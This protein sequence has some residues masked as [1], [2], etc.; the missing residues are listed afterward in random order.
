MK[1]IRVGVVG[2]GHRGR[3][4]LNLSAKGFGDIVEPAAACDIRPHNWYEKQW[5][6]DAPMAE[7]FPNAQFFEDYDTMLE[8]A[9]LDVVIVETGADIHAEFCCKALAR[10]INVLSDIPVVASLSEAEELW[11]AAEK[12]SAI[13][14]V[15]SNPNEQKFTVLLNEFF[16]KGLLGNPYCMEAEYIHWSLPGSESSIHLNENGDWRKLLSPIRYC[17]HSLG[18]LLTI[19][20]EVLRKVTCFGTGRHADDYGN[21][22]NKDDMQCAQFQTDSGIVIRVM[23]NGRCRADIGH[24]TYRVFGTQGYMEKTER[25]GKAVIRYNSQNE[26]DTKLKEI[27]GEY[28]PPAY[29]NDPRMVAGHGGVDFAMLDH[30]FIA[31]QN[32]GPA[33]ITLKEGLAMTLPGIYAEE[34]AKRGGELMR[35]R[36]PWDPDWTASF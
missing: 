13:I 5:L 6:S 36:Y 27:G 29:A 34:S 22:I 15:G 25:M 33:P 12:S 20:P 3:H 21:S 4:M 24:H 7:M 18:P 2:L 14:S 32:G 11:K 19:V 31:I 30:F 10:N 23:R 9:D 26:L 35:M 16:K 17:T 28:M 1:K 8:K